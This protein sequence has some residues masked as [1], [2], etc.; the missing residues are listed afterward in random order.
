MA[1]AYSAPKTAIFGIHGISP[2]QRYGFQDQ[3]AEGLLNALNLA[4]P[5]KWTSLAYWPQIEPVTGLPG[6]RA[7]ALRVCRVGEPPADAPA[8]DEQDGDREPSGPVFDVYEGYWSPLTKGRTNAASLGA[9]LVKCLLSGASATASIPASVGKLRWDFGYIGTLLAGG[10]LGV[11]VALFL[12]L[13]GLTQF[14]SAFG[15]ASPGAAFFVNPLATVLKLPLPAFAVL[16]LEGL[17]AFVTVELFALIGSSRGREQQRTGMARQA[18]AGKHLKATM[19]ASKRWHRAAIRIAV[20]LAALLLAAAVAIPL[21]WLHQPQV[22]WASLLLVAAAAVLRA[23]RWLLDFAVTEVLGDIQVYTTHDTTA[24]D[25]AVR[26][27]VI[28]TV[29]TSLLAVLRARDAS[30]EKPLYDRVHIA[31]HSLGSTIAIDV[32]I[33][34]RQLFLE[35][36]VRPDEWSTL[37]SLMTFG[38]ALEKTRFFFDVRYPTPTAR[39]DQWQNDVYGSLFTA[40]RPALDTGQGIYWSNVWYF[41]DIVA[42]EIVSYTSDVEAGKANFVWSKDHGGRPGER[43]ICANVRLPSLWSRWQFIHGNYLGDTRFWDVALPVF[44]EGA[45]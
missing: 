7:T 36:A 40:E 16:A 35:G 44:R 37:R 14:T 1:D 18:A 4:E 29:A 26:E 8:D 11:L 20:V 23:A 39:Y 6:L 3:L 32:L 19:I 43:T 2:I 15:I 45:G 17:A 9:W 41:E 30:G 21:V 28:T 5:G 27:L 24:T 34:L 25:F 10:A 13:T 31:A 33:R 22:L 38:T 42:N 12:G